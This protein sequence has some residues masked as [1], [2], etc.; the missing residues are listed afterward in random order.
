MKIGTSINH[1]IWQGFDFQNWYNAYLLIASP[2]LTDP[3]KITPL[4][5]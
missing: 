3:N 1:P 2:N 4:R 5:A